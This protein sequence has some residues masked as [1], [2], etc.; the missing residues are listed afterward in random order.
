MCFPLPQGRGSLPVIGDGGRVPTLHGGKINI[1]KKSYPR[2][3]GPHK[4]SWVRQ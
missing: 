1:T 2:R 4:G 3:A